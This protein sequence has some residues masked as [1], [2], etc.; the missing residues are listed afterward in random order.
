MGATVQS[1]ADI[2]IV[3]VVVEGFQRIKFFDGA[4]DPKGTV[5]MIGGR[6]RQGKTSLLDAIE[7]AVFGV[8]LSHKDPINDKC[9]EARVVIQTTDFTA[10]RRYF[11][12]DGKVKT[13]IAV[14]DDAGFAVG[15]NKRF[16]ESRL[17]EWFVDPLAFATSKPIE[18]RE[19][20]CD[21]V[22]I[23]WEAYRLE[24][25]EAREQEK[26][27]SAR[28]DDIRTVALKRKEEL[29]ALGTTFDEAPDAEIDV[30]E[31]NAKLTQ[32]NE[33]IQANNH[34]RA[35]IV[36]NRQKIGANDAEI[37]RLE[38]QIAQL[39]ADNERRLKWEQ[40][41][42]EPFDPDVTEIVAKI[43]AANGLNAKARAKLAVLQAQQD[44]DGA[45]SARV[46]AARKEKG[47]ESGFRKKLAEAEFPVKGMTIDEDGVLLNG[48]VIAQA[49]GAE[50]IEVGMAVA[51]A[52]KGRMAP[53]LIRDGNR[54]DADYRRLIAEVAERHGA[55]IF[56]EYVTE[57]PA[58]ESRC[59]FVMEDGTA[60]EVA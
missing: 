35:Q 46:E 33:Q 59:T 51:L 18:Q 12:K 16:L 28:R 32:A 8:Q 30:T 55:Q 9:N 57:D 56:M 42:P 24:L 29:E 47:I 14:V 27:M 52:K 48:V 21:L 43:A 3:R 15:D 39:Q 53:I 44:Y 23:D 22:G 1:K 4:I 37:E 7:V 5:V 17:S 54:L 50:Q 6:N 38:Q 41:N 36:G 26:F 25:K 40:E 11:K 10:T 49:S 20:V 31:L 60:K 13:E 58:G 2:K 19:I 45:E 34:K